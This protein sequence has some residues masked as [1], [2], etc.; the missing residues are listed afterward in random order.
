[1][2]C[3]VTGVGPT[4]RAG[5]WHRAHQ[6]VADMRQTHFSPRVPCAVAGWV[7]WRP[8]GETHNAFFVVSKSYTIEKEICD[9]SDPRM[10]VVLCTSADPYR[11]LACST[12]Q[13]TCESCNAWQRQWRKAAAV[14]SAQ[15]GPHSLC[16]TCAVSHGRGRKPLPTLRASGLVPCTAAS[17]PPFACKAQWL[18]LRSCCAG[19]QEPQVFKLQ[20]CLP[21]RL[22][23]MFMHDCSVRYRS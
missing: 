16:L 11:K 7:L 20:R 1:M 21:A 22:R 14:F 8:L 2:H 15:R 19:P 4:S 5:R 13:R 18:M 6:E 3:Q 12:S 17:D 9:F 10:H 23:M